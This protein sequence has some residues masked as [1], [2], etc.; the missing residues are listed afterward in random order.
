MT[1]RRAAVAVAL[2]VFGAVA[3]LAARGSI[4]PPVVAIAAGVLVIPW[5][6]SLR[7][8]ARELARDS[9]RRER[10]A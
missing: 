7:R 3:V 4:P 1:R 10:E 8:R 6:L 9:A 2:L 5:T